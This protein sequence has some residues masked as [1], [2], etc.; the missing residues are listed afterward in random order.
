MARLRFGALCRIFLCRFAVVSFFLVWLSAR[1]RFGS[2]RL[3]V[4]SFVLNVGSRLVLDRRWSV[5]PA[6][7]LSVILHIIAAANESTV[8]QL[9]N[10]NLAPR[11][12][13]HFLRPENEATGLWPGFNFLPR[14]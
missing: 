6:L 14:C 5:R 11:Q 4:V 2:P 9:G 12:M 7:M 3:A 10:S 13:W 8:G 1:C